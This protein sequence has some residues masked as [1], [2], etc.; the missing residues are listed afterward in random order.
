MSALIDAEIKKIIEIGKNHMSS[1]K[2]EMAFNYLICAIMCYNTLDYNKICNDI[3]DDNIT[4]GSYDG[5]IDFVYFDEENSK[6]IIGQNKLSDN[7]TVNDVVAEIQKINLTLKNFK[8]ISTTDYNQNLRQRLRNAVDQLNLEN[9]DNIELIFASLSKFNKNKVLE[10]VEDDFNG[11]EIT[12]LYEEDIERVIENLQSE[13]PFINEFKFDIDQSRNVLEYKSENYSGV[14]LNIKASSLQNAYEKFHDNG[15]F[16]LNIRRYIKSRN[17]DVGIIHSINNNNTDFWFKNNGLTIACKDYNMD[18]NT[19]KVY[20]FSIVNGGQ[21]TTLIAEN[22]ESKDKDFYVMCKI[23]KSTQD[24]DNAE[25]MRFFNDIAEATNSQKP[26]QP[27][28]LKSNAPEMLQLQ[29]ILENRGCYLEIKRGISFSKQNKNKKIKMKIKNDELAQ[30]YYSFVVQKPGIARS[31]KRTLFSNNVH[32]KKIFHQ[33]YGRDKDKLDFLVDLIT[34]NDRVN[35]VIRGFKDKKLSKKM[36][37]EEINILTNS[38]MAIMALMGVIYRLVNKDIDINTTN[39][40][41]DLKE[42]KY[43]SF[44][45]NYKKDDID[46]KIVE[47]VYELVIELNNSFKLEFENE[48]VTSIS[49]FLKTDKKYV[50]KILDSY[51]TQ[52]K[53]RDNLEKL[54][55]YYGELF[56]RK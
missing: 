2:E 8:N 44:I 35:Y 1:L 54:I 15:L 5:G 48:R 32:Y 37:A 24:L 31:S 13:L 41:N 53:I 39:I 50:S 40:E 43:G 56:K 17:V 18:G 6:V 55:D 38:K 29:K 16:N 28:D 27:R 45:S 12:F 14:V 11:A 7:C 42:F 51:I 36:K 3:S 4:D 47:L 33:K 9:E 21:T 22:F 52:L 26:I 10:K 49:N 30:I 25:S 23:I 19:V 46:N 20:N 34:L